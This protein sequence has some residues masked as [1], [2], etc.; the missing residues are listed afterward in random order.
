MADWLSSKDPVGTIVVPTRNSG[1]FLEAC[2]ASIRDQTVLVELIVVDNHSDDDTCVI[3]RR[4]ADRVVV[5][6]P[7]RSRQRNIGLELAN[8]DVVAF[9]DSDMVLEQ[10]VM[11]EAISVL[12]NPLN[13]GAV[14]PERAFGKGFFAQCRDLEKRLYLDNSD[15]ESARVFRTAE[16]R[17]VGGYREDLRAGEDWDLADRV[18]GSQVDRTSSIIWHDE[19]SIDLRSTF[20]KKRYYGRSFATYLSVRTSGH[21]RSLGRP[22]VLARPDLWASPSLTLGLAVLKSIEVAGLSVGVLE[23]RWSS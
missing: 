14:I 5:A 11:A 3:A 13:L 7:E 23:S 6:G 2:L 8:T 10:R 16:V 15:V 19:G 20:K 12:A 17:A 18:A 4:F 9:I 21:H 1:P 22:A